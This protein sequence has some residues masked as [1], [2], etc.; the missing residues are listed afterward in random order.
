MKSIYR[1]FAPGL[2]ALI[3]TWAAGAQETSRAAQPPVKIAIFVNNRADIR[4]DDKTRVF[5]DF[6]IA[7]TTGLGFQI[8][9]R[10]LATKAVREFP[11]QV[12]PGK[13]LDKLLARESSAL[14]LAGMLGADY[15]M[16]ATVS[17]FGQRTQ[18][19][20]AR[21]I[22]IDQHT[23]TLAAT[24]RVNEGV[25]GGSLLSDTVVIEEQQRQT[26]FE[27]V[28]DTDLLNRMLDNASRKIADSL[29]QKLDSKGTPFLLPAKS[30]LATFYV[31]ATLNGIAVP[32]AQVS[33]DGKAFLTSQTY[34]VSATGVTV[35]LDGAAIGSTPGPF[36]A[37]PGLHKMK[38]TR[39]DFETWERTVNI[40][41][42]QELSIALELSST[43]YARWQDRTAFLSELK[44]DT[45][46][47][48]GKYELMRGFAQMLRQSG[49]KVDVKEDI[50]VNT[51]E[52]LTIKKSQSV[53]N[54]D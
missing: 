48:E 49:Y 34:P 21:G 37:A 20:R 24:Y 19:I 2:A 44:K 53:F 25:S 7:Q 16:A 40:Y 6:L 52:G 32:D 51:T 31:T 36:K 38:I 47:T 9:S 43:G 26:A 22:E 14:R 8:I 15:V 50:N 10:E 28:V 18:K 42:G 54:Q 12:L 39:A 46:L 29:R 1:I 41:D 30:E 3:F 17:S 35:E 5:E 23:Y 4:F 11:E 27:E 45:L 33:E 13:D